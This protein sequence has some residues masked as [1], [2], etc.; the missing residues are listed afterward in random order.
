MDSCV[1]V[2]LA[3]E[4]V[5]RAGHVRSG[6]GDLPLPAACDQRAIDRGNGRVLYLDPLVTPAAP[7]ARGKVRDRVWPPVY[8]PDPLDGAIV[9]RDRSNNEDGF[10]LYARRSWFE[11]DCTVTVGPWQT[12][13]TLAADTTRHRPN[14]GKVRRSIPV[15]EI[16]DVPGFMVRWEYAVASYNEAGASRL[17]P[18]GGFLGPEAFC[19]SGLE[20]PPDL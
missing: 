11:V 7:T 19:D 5:D 16:P 15:P 18:I 10:R 20:P 9:W 13:T 12:V 3:V 8:G 14:H 1:P 2:S 17:V 4:V 6:I